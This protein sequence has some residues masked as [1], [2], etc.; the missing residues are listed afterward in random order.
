MDQ[1]SSKK[2][3]EIIFETNDKINAIVEEIRLIRFSKMKEKESK[4]DELRKEFEK[5][6]SLEEKKVNEV[7]KNSSPSVS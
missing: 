5:I 3:D 6:M 7:M 2:I 1:E 4:Y